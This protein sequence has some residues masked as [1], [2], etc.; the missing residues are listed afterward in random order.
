MIGLAQI[1][2]TLGTIVP[3]RG[4]VL[5]ILWSWYLVPL[6]APALDLL[7][8]IGLLIVASLIRGTRTPRPDEPQQP[9]AVLW[10]ITVAIA[11]LALVSGWA[12]L[13]LGAVLS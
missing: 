6:G 9:F 12:Y 8:A 4:W 10:I 13:Q 5:S 2:I 7:H 3:L 11:L 1:L